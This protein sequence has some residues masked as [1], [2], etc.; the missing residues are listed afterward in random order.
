MLL[1]RIMTATPETLPVEATVGRAIELLYSLDVRHL[2]VVDGTTLVGML[3]DRD[4]RGIALASTGG[5]ETELAAGR[6]LEKKVTEVMNGNV[7]AV[8]VDEDL[9]EV[10][11]LMIEHRVGAL[12]VID[13]TGDLV[14]ILSYVDLL[15]Y[16]RE[17][18]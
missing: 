5:D 14:G 1:A 12:P 9:D 2:P 13:D 3:S 11:T 17:L 16:M 7:V 15:S 6:Y 18:L 4:L 10:I 8:H